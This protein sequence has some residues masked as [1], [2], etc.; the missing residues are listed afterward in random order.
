M[1]GARIAAV[2]EAGLIETEIAELLLSKNGAAE[3]FRVGMIWFCFYAPSEVDQSASE[4]LFRNW[5]GEALYAYHETDPQTGPILRSIGTPCL[6]EADVP[7]DTFGYGLAFKVV[8]RFLI[9]RG[10]QTR[11]P[12]EH[13]DN[14]KRPIPA[15][16]ICRV[17]R[18]P[19]PDFLK[20]K[21]VPAGRRR[22][23]ARSACEKSARSPR[24][25]VDEFSTGL[26]CALARLATRV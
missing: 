18:F 7:I 16:N 10:L 8:R 11:E 6:V 23:R 1:L 2:R 13:D 22:L 21:V 5:S 4:R 15:S 25:Y 3:T 19:E 26:A 24:P 9:D 17:I 20:L 12:I 14:A